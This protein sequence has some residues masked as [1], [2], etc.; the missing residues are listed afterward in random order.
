MSDIWHTADEK[1]NDGVGM[2]VYYSKEYDEELLVG[3]YNTE[4]EDFRPLDEY[5]CE[6]KNG[7]KMVLS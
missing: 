3:Y 5:Y 2:V 6:E 4:Y 1:P 7:Q